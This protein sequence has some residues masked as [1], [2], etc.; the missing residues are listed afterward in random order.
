MTKLTNEEMNF[1]REE[2]GMNFAVIR[3]GIVTN[4]LSGEIIP[5][6]LLSY[7]RVR[8]DGVYRMTEA[9]CGGGMTN[10]KGKDINPT[11]ESI[12]RYQC[13][14]GRRNPKCTMYS[15]LKCAVYCFGKVDAFTL[16]IKPT[17]LL[18]M[19]GIRKEIEC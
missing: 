18:K 7:Q 10:G 8:P 1:L 12:E 14:V 19:V 2:T 9:T 11:P 3:D 6:E 17:D 4:Q 16:S 5:V 13:R 15:T